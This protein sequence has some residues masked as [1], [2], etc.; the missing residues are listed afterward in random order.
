MKKLFVRTFLGL[1]IL[2]IL[3][4]VYSNY[5]ELNLKEMNKINFVVQKA[6]D[7]NLKVKTEEKSDNVLSES[8]LRDVIVDKN[9]VTE[10]IKDQL[11]EN[12]NS[13][14]CVPRKNLVYLKTHKT[15][16]SAVQNVLMRK[17]WKEKWIVLRPRNDHDFGYPGYFTA[18]RTMNSKANILCHHTR[19]HHQ[20]IKQL[21]PDDSLWV[22]SV[23]EPLSLYRSSIK[24]F[25][26]IVPAFKRIANNESIEKWYDNAEKY[27]KTSP[28]S[29]YSFFTRSHM[30]YDFGFDNKR[31]ADKEYVKKAV[32][33]IDNIF[34]LI[35]VSDYFDESMVLLSDLLC[36][37]IEEFACL[38]LNARKHAPHD[39]ID[40]KRIREKVR[41][42]NEADATIFDH[43]NATL[44]RKIK[45]FGTE[46]MSIQ[47][48]K[49]NNERDRVAG[50]CLEAS[51]PVEISDMKNSKNNYYQPPGV[52]M[53]GY[54]LSEYGKSNELCQN[55]VK[56]ENSFSKD[57]FIRQ[58]SY[59]R[60]K[61]RVKRRLKRRV[62]KK[63][64]RERH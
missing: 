51:Q 39:P 22:S 3:F 63:T 61:R 41:R 32:T 59:S 43:F 55:F 38:T 12:S 45:E 53:T 7:T 30:L 15:A 21:M 10:S 50:E 11:I 4:L 2:L 9:E 54:Q 46:K 58:Q 18:P 60:T 27:V 44:W 28:K 25:R 6:E 26:P 42:W 31:Q 8:V 14:K 56:P 36:W 57:L 33:E 5:S 35:L 48:E 17:A 24:Y 34:D 1:V 62:K 37:P 52:S 13:E 49:L 47:L 64:K 20:R 16:S 29:V 23:R 40:E 19:F